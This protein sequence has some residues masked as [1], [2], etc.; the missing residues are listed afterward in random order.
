MIEVS[1]LTKYYGDKMGVENVSFTINKGEVVGL[2]GPNGAGKSTIM[3]MLTGYLMP[4]AGSITIDGIDA[5]DKPKE[6]AAKIGFMPEIPPLYMDM[7]VEEYLTF[8]SEIKGVKK[9]ER[10][11][12]VAKVME[13]ASV[14]NVKDRIIKNLSKGYRQRV[15]LAQALVGMPEILILDEPTVGL[16]PKQ[17]AEFRT[18]LSELSKNHT[19][20]LSSHILS[21]I[22]MVCEKI[23]IINRG[24]IVAEDTTVHLETEGIKGDEFMLRLRANEKQALSVVAAVKGVKSVE[25]CPDAVADTKCC[26]LIVTGEDDET[27]V[28]LNT[29]LYKAEMPIMELVNRRMTL[30]QAF[31]NLVGDQGK[32]ED[33]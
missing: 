25:S 19:I 24:R 7:V 3:K 30:E 16:D 20:I 1:G 31:L 32:E 29:A 23:I 22:N 4:T 17:I 28:R 10:K 6:A 13:T 14:V 8:A 5:I 2:L 15:G 11:A 27:R 18:L 21:E 12:M 9:S 26:C 33:K